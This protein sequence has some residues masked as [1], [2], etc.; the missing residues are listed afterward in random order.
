[1][2]HP[3]L[4]AVPDHPPRAPLPLL[5]WPDGLPGY[6]TKL[7]PRIDAEPSRRL[8]LMTTETHPATFRG[9][10][11]VAN[12]WDDRWTVHGRRSFHDYSRSW[13]SLG[14]PPTDLGPLTVVGWMTP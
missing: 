1:M 9:A 11:V 4:H 10:M 2:N 5:L 7:Q 12:L 6:G 8:I 3:R 13:T 14:R